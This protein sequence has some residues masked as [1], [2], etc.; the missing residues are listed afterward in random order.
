MTG[1]GSLRNGLILL[2]AAAFA[3]GCSMEMPNFVGREGGGDGIYRLGGPEPP[4]EARAVAL[5]QTQAERALHGVI[6]RVVG[7]APTQG[8]Y[9][10]N[11]RPLGGGA[12]DAAGILSFELVAFPPAEPQAVG[13]ARTRVLTAGLFVPN[14]TLE[15]LRGFRVAG[16]GTVQTVTLR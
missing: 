5:R 8:Y 7:E 11:L 16:R 12:P 2:A 15:D 1:G 4:P 10:A 14:K 3:G 6:L 13:P 9:S